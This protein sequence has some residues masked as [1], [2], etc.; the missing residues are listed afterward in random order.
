MHLNLAISSPKLSSPEFQTSQLME[1]GLDPRDW[2]L[3]DSSAANYSTRRL[4]HRDDEDI[5]LDAHLDESGEI[6]ELELIMASNV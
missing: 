5:Q 3:R 4:Q 6:K 1:F 2:L